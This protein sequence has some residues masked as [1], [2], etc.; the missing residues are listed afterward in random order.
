MEILNLGGSFE[1]SD[2]SPKKKKLKVVIGIG[3]LAAVMGMGSTLAAS[4]NINTSTGGSVEFGQGIAATA[5][6]DTSITV[7]PFATYANAALGDFLFSSLKISDIN[8][9]DTA[10]CGGKT[11]VI[12]GYTAYTESVTAGYYTADTTTALPLNLTWSYSAGIVTGGT[13]A[14]GTGYNDGIAIAL[15]D[16][17]STCTIKVHGLNQAKG[18]MSCT[19]VAGNTGSITVVLYGV[20]SDAKVGIPTSAV[21]KITIESS[22]STPADY[23]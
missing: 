13:H 11:L 10:A 18:G 15:A 4:I 22:L 5:A 6:C 14:S 21:S 23:A 1:P 8:N 16:D 2:R 3:L 7:T 20:A 12:K 19:A 17:G 9:D